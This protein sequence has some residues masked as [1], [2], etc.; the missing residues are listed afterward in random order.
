MMVAA[1]LRV[2]DCGE[3]RMEFGALGQLETHLPFVNSRVPD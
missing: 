1:C 2:C 3:E